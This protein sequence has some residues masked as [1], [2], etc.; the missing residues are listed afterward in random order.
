MLLF[1]VLG[2]YD[3][4]NRSK[5]IGLALLNV[6]ENERPDVII[7]TEMFSRYSDNIINALKTDYPYYTCRLGEECSGN[8]WDKY[9]ENCSNFVFTINGGVVIMSKYPI[10]YKVQ[11]IFRNRAFCT[12]DYYSNKGAAY[13]KVNKQEHPYHIIGTHM[14]ADH[15]NNIQPSIRNKQLEEIRELVEYLKIPK[16]EPIIVGGD[17]NIPYA[18]DVKHQTIKKLLFG[19]YNYTFEPNYGSFSAI[20]NNYAK[21]LAEYMN[22]P[23]NYDHTLDY[24]VYLI[25]YLKPINNPRMRVFN[26]KTLTPMYWKYMKKKLPY[27][28][29]YYSDPS[30]HYPVEIEYFYC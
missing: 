20:S 15:G 29:G 6:P 8:R 13:V 5:S 25:D 21:C 9:R 28:E 19:E 12:P 2:D 22:Y 24:V 3:Q 10:T 17:F 23:I 1:R 4:E 7:F 27:T 26:L 16:N 14:Q 11:Y 30:D 18:E